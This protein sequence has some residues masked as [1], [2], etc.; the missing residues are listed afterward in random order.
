MNKETR[1]L[2]KRWPANWE[3]QLRNKF[4]PF[5]IPSGEL[6]RTMLQCLAVISRFLDEPSKLKTIVEAYYGK[7]ALE[8]KPKRQLRPVDVKVVMEVWLGVEWTDIARK[9][10]RE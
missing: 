2:V 7:E 6:T 5:E 8:R 10:Q 3:A 9:G 1:L 4:F